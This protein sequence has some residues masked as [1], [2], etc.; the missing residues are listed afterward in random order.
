MSSKFTTRCNDTWHTPGAT[1]ELRTKG[2]RDAS[3]QEQTMEAS[4]DLFDL[5]LERR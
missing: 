5:P 3:V 2:G 1:L 4:E